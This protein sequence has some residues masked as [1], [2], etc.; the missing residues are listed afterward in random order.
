MDIVDSPSVCFHMV[1]SEPD[2]PLKSLFTE[3]VPCGINKSFAVARKGV[4]CCHCILQ[5]PSVWGRSS[6]ELSGGNSQ[7]CGNGDNLV[8]SQ[9]LIQRAAERINNQQLKIYPFYKSTTARM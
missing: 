4:P 2:G 8:A 7:T 3:R 5:E 9:L 6:R 1:A